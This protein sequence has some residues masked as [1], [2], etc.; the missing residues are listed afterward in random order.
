MKSHL[1]SHKNLYNTL[2]IH[3][4]PKLSVEQCVQIF[5]FEMNSK[6]NRQN[7]LNRSPF[8]SQ[9]S[10]LQETFHAIS[11]ELRPRSCQYPLEIHPRSALQLAHSHQWWPWTFLNKHLLYLSVPPIALWCGLSPPYW[12]QKLGDFGKWIQS[13]A[14]THHLKNI[15]LSNWLLSN[16]GT[17]SIS[18][19][20]H[21]RLCRRGWIII[22]KQSNPP[23]SV[24]LLVS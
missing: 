7:I 14:F 3:R 16:L 9:F 15:S 12:Y 8:L 1:S 6:W 17:D 18:H 20:L 10:W 2:G 4:N 22:A 5:L 24:G 19:T 23:N 11:L 13:T 21:S